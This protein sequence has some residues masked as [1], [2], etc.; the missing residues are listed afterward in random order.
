MRH[1]K[2]DYKWSFFYNSQQFDN[3]CKN[4]DKSSI[5]PSFK[6]IGVKNV[7]ISTLQRTKETVKYLKYNT[8][9]NIIST[10]L[11]DEVPLKSFIECSFLLPT[12][13]WL[14]IGRIQW[15]I[16]NNRQNETRSQ[17]KNRIVKLMDIIENQNKDCLLVG[18]GFYFSQMQSILKKRNYAGARTKYLKNGVII[19]FEK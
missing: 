17:T 9:V 6:K 2:V 4:Y 18:H 14:I 16:G 3:A 10:N 19:E 11:M 8:N 15:Y 13:S 5:I 12:F 1:F 7:Y